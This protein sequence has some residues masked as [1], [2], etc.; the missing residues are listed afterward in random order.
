MNNYSYKN[1]KWAIAKELL[2]SEGFLGNGSRQDLSVIKNYLLGFRKGVAVYDIESSISTYAKVL[3]LV[4][5]INNSKSKIL[6][7]GCPVLLENVIPSLLLGSQ[8]DYVSE[9]DWVPGML[10]NKR[11]FPDLIINFKREKQFSNKECLKEQI[12]LVAFVDEAS[13]FSYVDYPILVNLKAEGTAKMYFNL[14][15]QLTTINNVKC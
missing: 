10:T 4:G 15:K 6:F 13:D 11:Y 14:I 12:P 7:V 9:K 3:D 2:S 5:N 8:H 1:V